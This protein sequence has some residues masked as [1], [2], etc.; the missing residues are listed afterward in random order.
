MGRAPGE[1][2]EDHG[3][4]VAV[5]SAPGP[6]FPE[7]EEVGQAEPPEAEQSG[8][9]RGTATDPWSN[10]DCEPSAG[11]E[12]HRPGAPDTLMGVWRSVGHSVS[13]SKTA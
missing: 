10:A 11:V 6:G 8:G 4:V 3:G 13:S 5:G 7:A 12:R 2:D 9:D 1:P